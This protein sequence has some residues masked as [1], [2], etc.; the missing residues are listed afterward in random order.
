MKYY[1]QI[2]DTTC[3]RSRIIVENKSSDILGVNIQQWISKGFQTGYV[4]SFFNLCYLEDTR[5]GHN[6]V[7]DLTMLID[8]ECVENRLVF[9]IMLTV[10]LNDQEQIHSCVR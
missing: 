5:F 8:W 1:K 6:E 7:F 2:C 4:V 3:R 10:L 9:N